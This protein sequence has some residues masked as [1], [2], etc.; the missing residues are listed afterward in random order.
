MWIFWLRP[1]H[2]EGSADVKALRQEH[3]WPLGVIPVWVE[4]DEWERVIAGGVG[5][6]EQ[7]M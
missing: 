2:V 4:Q 6:G 1:L 7:S 5:G 3:A